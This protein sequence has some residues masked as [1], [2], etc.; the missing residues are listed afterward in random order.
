M[1]CMRTA[2]LQAP[3]PPVTH[4]SW[5]A[6]HDARGCMAIATTQACA[7]S[8]GHG[9]ARAWLGPWPRC[10]P[11]PSHRHVRQ[12]LVQDPLPAGRTHP[13]ALDVEVDLAGNAQ[14]RVP[15]PQLLL[16]LLVGLLRL[17]LG[18]PPGRV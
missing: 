10:L 4:T 8:L 7:W 14:Q 3:A 9:Y 1:C 16:L 6:V 13:P 2:P 11:T 5:M 12:A 17:L 15:G 18:L